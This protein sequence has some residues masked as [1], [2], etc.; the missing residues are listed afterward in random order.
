MLVEN[1]KQRKSCLCDDG[2]PTTEKNGERENEKNFT[3]NEK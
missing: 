2:K 1:A 3:S